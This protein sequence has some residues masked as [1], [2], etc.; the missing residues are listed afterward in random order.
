MVARGIVVVPRG[1][2][3]ILTKNAY[4]HTLFQARADALDDFF[5]DDPLVFFGE[6]GVY[7]EN[8]IRGRSLNPVEK[9]M[10]G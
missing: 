9:G 1:S 8:A 4:Y 10:I 7:L 5:W 6:V 3:F 2:V